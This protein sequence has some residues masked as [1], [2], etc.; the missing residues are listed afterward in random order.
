M[1]LLI[2]TGLLAIAWD[3]FARLKYPDKDYTVSGYINS[4]MR[5]YIIIGVS[6]GLLL[7]YLFPT[8]LIPMILAGLVVHFAG[9]QP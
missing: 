6:M 3:I 7:G 2:T 8:A 9:W 4:L 5:K 1:W